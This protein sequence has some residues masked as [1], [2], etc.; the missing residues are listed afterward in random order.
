MHASSSL[1]NGCDNFKRETLTKH[2]KSKSHVYCR[3]YYLSRSG[4]SKAATQQDALPEVLARHETAQR[5]DLQ[6][7]LEITPIVLSCAPKLFSC[8]P[9]ILAVRLEI[10]TW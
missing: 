6:R 10:Y 2:L 4:R 7:A 3:D 9:K 8:A 1:V 5:A